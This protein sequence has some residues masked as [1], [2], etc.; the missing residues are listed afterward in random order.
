[1]TPAAVQNAHGTLRFTKYE[2]VKIDRFV[3]YLARYGLFRSRNKR[4][5]DKRAQREDSAAV[6]Q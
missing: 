2:N 3:P 1:M 6:R 4:G 5:Y